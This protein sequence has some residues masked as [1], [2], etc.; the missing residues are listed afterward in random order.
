MAPQQAS[1][2]SL[3]GHP[4]LKCQSSPRVARLPVIDAQL[5]RTRR[6]RTAKTTYLIPPVSEV[7]VHIGIQI[8]ANTCHD[9][10]DLLLES[11]DDTGF[12]CTSYVLAGGDIAVSLCLL[13]RCC[14]DYLSVWLSALHMIACPGQV[15]PRKF[16]RTS[17]SKLSHLAMVPRNTWDELLLLGV[18]LSLSM[19]EG[20]RLKVISLEVKA[21]GI[22]SSIGSD[23]GKNWVTVGLWIGSTVREYVGNTSLRRLKL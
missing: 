20:I 18:L 2:N 3:S 6:E 4:V 23:E 1:S 17:I 21:V 7:Q 15:S 22:L 8:R 10:S 11:T 5:T 9:M 19:I 16:S 12:V 14:K 13:G